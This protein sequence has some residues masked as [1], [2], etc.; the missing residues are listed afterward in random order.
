MLVVP[1]IDVLHGS[2][3]RLVE[4]DYRQ[5]T[6]YGGRRGGAGTGPAR[7]PSCCTSSISKGRAPASPIRLSGGAPGRGFAA[8]SGG[9][10]DPVVGRG[11][12]SA[13]HRSAARVLGT[14]AVWAPATV[15]SLLSEV[16]PDRVVAALDVR[17]GRAAGLGVDRPGARPGRCRRRPVTAGSGAGIAHLDRAGRHHDRTRSRAWTRAAA[18]RELRV[19]ALGWGRLARRHQGAGG[20]RRRGRGRRPRALRGPVHARRG[21]RRHLTSRLVV[22][23]SERT[24]I[25]LTTV[26]NS[27]PPTRLP[28]TAHP[29]SG[30][31]SE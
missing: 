5:V 2:V 9:W 31:Q 8:L 16:G 11:A 4:G 25:S 1:A 14:A 27:N 20:G 22:G 17:H 24:S 13:H 23:L 7:A 3:V 30:A 26:T 21:H 18:R 19:I 15:A 12:R 6:D 29:A 10:R 28:R